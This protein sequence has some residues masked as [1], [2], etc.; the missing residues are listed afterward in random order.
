MTSGPKII[1]R[2]KNAK[3]IGPTPVTIILEQ[4]Q[5]IKKLRKILLSKPCGTQTVSYLTF[6]SSIYN[7]EENKEIIKKI[8]TLFSLIPMFYGLKS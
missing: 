2:T 1:S 6:L 3:N 8:H 4:K 5:N 7:C